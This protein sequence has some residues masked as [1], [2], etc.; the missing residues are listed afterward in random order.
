MRL[1]RLVRSRTVAIGA[2]SASS[3]RLHRTSF[4]GSS[5]LVASRGVR[6][7]GSIRRMR[8]A[9]IGTGIAG[10]GAAHALAGAHEVE[11]FEKKAYAGGHTHTVD[12]RGPR[13]PPRRRHGLH[14]PQRAQLPAARR[15]AR[16]ARR[17]DRRRRRCRS[18][19][20]APAAASSSRARAGAAAPQPAPAAPAPLPARAS[21]GSS[22][23]PSA[24]LDDDARRRRRSAAFARRGAATRTT[25]RTTGSCRCARRSGRSPPRG[26]LDLPARYALGFLANHGVLGFRHLRWRTVVGGSR[27]YVARAARAHVGDAAPRAAR[28][29]SL[30]PYL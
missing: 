16:G 19:S 10:L 23:R 18:P 29:D 21:C 27:E 20:P 13:P 5:P 17:R 30:N 4:V 26:A 22:G 24:R 12:V 9:V 8:I 6:R 3:V 14:R 15:A 1:A 25:S 28:A 7:D 2:R 11:L